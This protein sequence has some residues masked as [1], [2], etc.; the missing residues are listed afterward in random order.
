MKNVIFLLIVCLR[1]TIGLQA[2]Q[3]LDANWPLG[4]L[5]YLNAGNYGNAMLTFLGDTV[6]VEK[7]SLNMNFESSVGAI[8]D[9][10][11]QL[12]F[13]TNGCYIATATGD[14]MPNGAGLNPGAVHE[15]VCPANGYISPRGVMI[16]PMPGQEYLYVVLHM[17][18]RYEPGEK[19]S[20]GPFYYS[21]VDM[22]Q[23]GGKGAVISKNNILADG[24]LE[25]FAVTRHGNGRDWWIL[26]PE[27]QSNRY[28]RF[29]ITPNAIQEQ[30]SLETGPEIT[31]P[32]MGSTTFSPDGLQFARFQN[33]K[34]VVFTF[35]RCTG[36]LSNAHE[37]SRPEH[38]FGG[39]GVAFSPDGNTL[40]ATE[41]MAVLSANLLLPNPTYDTVINTEAIT[42]AG[43]QFMQYAPNGKS[44]IMNI[45]HRSRF[46]STLD[47]TQATQAVY[48]QKAV[49]LPV[50]TVRTLPYFPNFRLFD[51]PGSIC[52]TLGI[53][54]PLSVFSIDQTGLPVFPNPATDVIHIPNEN[55]YESLELFDAL[56]KN[57]SFGKVE[58]SVGRLTL[59]IGHLAPGIYYLRLHK[60][61]RIWRGKFVKV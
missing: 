38:I 18:A 14:T 11:G 45:L 8:S 55:P 22:T 16:L 54:T 59:S 23:N 60:K 33:C 50:Y 40:Y 41:Q 2:Q 3:L 49:A 21:L 42:G 32:R 25:P 47:L 35:D 29:I 37:W 46:Y 43:L 1:F 6:K 39:G 30:T 53:N 7:T 19:L 51:L 56:G 17:G 28:R 36:N 48:I 57:I 58:V 44:L 61:G 4:T 9:T 27:N 52:D 10:T 31:C 26:L 20:L 34:T 13:Y 24:N 15:W 12:L 5:E